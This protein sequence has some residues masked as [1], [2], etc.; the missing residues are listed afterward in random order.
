MP[1]DFL[2][3]KCSCVGGDEIYRKIERGQLACTS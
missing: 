1:A 2:S 3:D